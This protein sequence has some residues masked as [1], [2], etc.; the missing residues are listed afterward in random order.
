MKKYRPTSGSEGCSFESEFCD[1]CY[2]DLMDEETGDY[3]RQCDI[4]DRVILFE[5]DDPKYPDEWRI[6]PATEKP[7]CSAFTE[8]KPFEE[9]D[10]PGQATF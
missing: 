10:I 2:H 9:L 4:H 8:T 3:I 6:C 1:K 5:I 7:V